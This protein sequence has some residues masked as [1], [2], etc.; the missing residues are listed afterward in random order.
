MN[1]APG[2][3]FVERLPDSYHGYTGGVAA[4]HDAGHNVWSD[5]WFGV[6]LSAFLK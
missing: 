2:P 6:R 5:S 3:R 1:V 4:W